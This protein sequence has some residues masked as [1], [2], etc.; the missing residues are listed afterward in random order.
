MDANEI[1]I[2]YVVPCYNVDK[3]LPAC[4]ASLSRQN[5]VGGAGIEYILVN[6]GSKDDTLRLL[7]EF[8]AH[9]A[10]ATV[11]D[12]EN[13]GVCAARNNGLKFA[14]GKYVYFHDG[15][16][17]LTEEASQVV[18]D[19]C[20]NTA[21]DI[22]IPKAYSVYE[23]DLNNKYDWNTFGKYQS[24]HFTTREF[25]NEIKRLPISVKVYKRELL[26]N[27]KIFFDEDLRV[28]EVYTFFFHAL[29]FSQTVTL[30]EGRM[31]IW[32]MRRG[33]TTIGYNIQRDR[34][35]I[36]TMHRIDEYAG[37]FDFDIRSKE[38]YHSSLYEIV[39]IFG[40]GKY[41]KERYSSEIGLFI[42]DL[43]KDKVL[44]ATLN[45]YIRKRPLVKRRYLD[46]YIMLHFPVR[47]AFS[48]LRVTNLLF[49]YKQRIRKLINCGMIFI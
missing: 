22:I 44:M 27:N 17:I 26:L 20:K 25:V 4:L 21:P 46:S 35:I 13:Q 5:I 32:V 48:L 42:K 18:Y 31:M 37:A 24:G 15:D 45:Y 43:I 41:K 9:D 36:K 30:S 49:V 10:R 33:G 14:K 34:E 1:Y 39:S 40:F 2:S 28:G 23:D 19:E 7:K 6:D 11:I 12:Q 8:A 16:D 47:C 29:A 38:S 3:Y